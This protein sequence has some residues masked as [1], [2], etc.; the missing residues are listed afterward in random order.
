VV[1]M[2]DYVPFTQWHLVTYRVWHCFFFFSTLL[3]VHGLGGPRKR[4]WAALTVLNYVCLFYYELIFVAFVAIFGAIYTAVLYRRTPRFMVYAWLLQAV[5]A[6][7][8]LGTLAVQLVAYLGWDEFLTDARYTLMARNEAGSAGAEGVNQLVAFYEKHNIVFWYNF[9]DGANYRFFLRFLASL[10]AF[11]LQSHTPFFSILTLILFAPWLVGHVAPIARRLAEL[12]RR[13]VPAVA[14]LLALVAL[15]LVVVFTLKLQEA[16]RLGLPTVVAGCGAAMVWIAWMT[17]STRIPVRQRLISAAKEGLTRD[18]HRIRCVATGALVIAAS[19]APFLMAHTR[20]EDLVPEPYS[21]PFLVFLLVYAICVVSLCLAA[22]FP[23]HFV[24]TASRLMDGASLEAKSRVFRW[25]VAG[26]GSLGAASPKTVQESRRTPGLA[27][28]AFQAGVFVFVLALMGLDVEGAHARNIETRALLWS[29]LL[30]LVSARLAVRLLN[31][32]SAG[33]WSPGTDIPPARLFQATLAMAVAAM[34]MRYHGS[35]FYQGYQLIWAEQ[36]KG[37]WIPWIGPIALLGAVVLACHTIVRGLDNPSGDDRRKSLHPVFVYLACGGAAYL[38]VYYLSPGYVHTGYLHRG[39]GLFVYLTALT[40]AVPVHLLLESVRSGLPSLKSALGR[41]VLSPGA[42]HC[43]LSL[44]LLVLVSGLWLSLQIRW[45]MLLPPNHYAFLKKLAQKPYKGA[46]F[47]VANY[48]APV[49][50]FTG[51]WAYD[52]DMLPATQMILTPDGFEMKR[53]RRYLW[54]ADRNTN[55]SYRKPDYF[56]C[57]NPQNFGTLAATLG[58]RQSSH[59]SCLYQEIIRQDLQ[60]IPRPLEHR[61]VDWDREGEQRDHFAT[62]AI[63]KMDWEYPPFLKPAP[64][65]DAQHPVAI[66]VHEQRSGPETGAYEINYQYRYTQQDNVPERP[67]LVELLSFGNDT[68]CSARGTQVVV[69]SSSEGS[70]LKL[71]GD[72]VGKVAIRL[73]PRSIRKDGQPY[74]SQIVRIDPHSSFHLRS[75]DARSR[76]EPPSNSP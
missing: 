21:V 30:A 22:A 3:C 44:G 17:L 23:L 37:W 52:G 32:M 6:V 73:T 45:V 50:A 53:D 71:P 66:A 1:L 24:Q 57:M 68:D 56:I 42:V 51:N 34:V 43:A 40:V 70:S 67:P 18:P 72:F 47:V 2:T 7:I 28:R 75:C 74:Y 64:G 46:T 41:G 14:G 27:A 13:D 26:A 54:L 33:R 69:L 36:L 12:F 61:L 31:W 76:P 4:T 29:V 63:V 55:P 16:Q 15:L 11:D 5:G 58:D 35:F 38:I 9:A 8:S 20:K 39:V 19:L 25:A 62:W 59:I 49:A 10:T 60:H 48:A 65:A